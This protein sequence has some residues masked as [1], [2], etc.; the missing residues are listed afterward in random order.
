M[1][2]DHGEEITKTFGARLRRIYEQD[3]QSLPSQITASLERLKRAEEQRPAAPERSARRQS[4]D[5]DL[6]SFFIAIGPSAIR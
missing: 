1:E 6:T 5:D 2:R 4:S 3:D